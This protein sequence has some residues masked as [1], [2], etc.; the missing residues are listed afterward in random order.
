MKDKTMTK[1]EHQHFKAWLVDAEYGPAVVI[2]QNDGH[3]DESVMLHM[4]QLRAVCQHFGITTADEQAAKTIAAMQRRLLALRDRI[5]DMEAYM[6]KFS[7]HKHADLSYELVNLSALADLAD[8]WCADFMPC[9]V[10][11]VTTTQCTSAPTQ[12]EQASLI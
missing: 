5:N 11:P 6:V 12:A 4:D 2:Q 9:E 10:S 7:D 8:E 1:L 3:T